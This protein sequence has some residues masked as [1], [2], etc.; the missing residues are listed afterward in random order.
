MW[1]GLHGGVRL[2]AAAVRGAENLSDVAHDV[3][4]QFESG[5]PG[6]MGGMGPVRGPAPVRQHH[7]TSNG[8]ADAAMDGSLA[9]R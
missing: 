8:T 1:V 2:R 5:G 9:P 6:G 4:V 7:S 3:L